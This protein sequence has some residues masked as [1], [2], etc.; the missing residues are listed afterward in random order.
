MKDY[1]DYGGGKMKK[2]T[3]D[4]FFETQSEKSFV[5]SIIVTEFFKVYFSIINHAGFSDDIY[6]IDLFSGPGKYKDGTYSTPLLLLDTIAS[7]KADDIRNKLHL[8]FNDENEE[9]YNSLCTNIGQHPVVPKLK[10]PPIIQNLRASEVNLSQ[11]LSGKKPK[12]SFIDPWGYID[13]SAEQIGELVKSIGSDCVLFF[14]SNRILQD[15]SK[16]YSQE[17][18][19]KIFGDM[20]PEAVKIQKDTCLSQPAKCKRFVSVFAQNLYKTYF[21]PLKQLGFR[22][23]VL[24]FSIDQDDVEKTSHHIVF[25]SKNHKAICE[26]KKIMVKHSNT[27]SSSLGFDSK[28]TF[29]ISMFS[30]SDDIES[31]LKAIISNMFLRAPRLKDSYYTLSEWLEHIDR[32]RMSQAYEVTP[33]T[34]E[35]L[36]QCLI[37]W[38]ANGNGCIEIEKPTGKIRSRITNSRKIKFKENFGG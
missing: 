28:D 10:H 7:F 17:H 29:K 12:F 38:D 3:T 26:M 30:R 36:K 34:E 23:F 15:L 14:N 18:M 27:N 2:T 1:K 13:V 33:Y 5:K 35:E 25:I 32:F 11:Y 31:E 8:I 22:L 16:D 6:Y 4:G 37:K 24:P 19:S 21:E 9:F 20:L